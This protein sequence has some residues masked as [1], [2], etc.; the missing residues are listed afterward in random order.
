MEQDRIQVIG[1]IVGEVFDTHRKRLR[2]L[3]KQEI[4]NRGDSCLVIQLESKAQV[5]VRE[6][7]ELKAQIAS[8]EQRLPADMR[9]EF[10]DILAKSE[11]RITA[12]Y[13][14]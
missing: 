5:W 12:L 2:E 14:R 1:N 6:G 3:L 7:E 11:G 13:Q 8:F 10:Q 9:A 4:S